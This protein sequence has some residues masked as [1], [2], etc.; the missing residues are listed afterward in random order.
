[1][2]DATMPEAAR[3]AF[4]AAARHLG[5]DGLLALR[6]ALERDDVRLQQGVTTTPP[7]LMCAQD[8]PCEGACMLGYAGWQG[9]GLETVGEVEEFFARVCYLT[10]EDMKE[11]AGIRGILNWFDETPRDKMIAALLPEVNRMLEIMA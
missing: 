5:R 7:P 11:P 6:D 8:F 4:R 3:I 1:M 2:T 9:H 10:D